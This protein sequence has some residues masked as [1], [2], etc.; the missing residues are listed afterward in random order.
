MAGS[1]HNTFLDSL[2]NI[3]ILSSAELMGVDSLYRRMPDTQ[4][5]ARELVQRGLLTGYQADQLARGNGARLLVGPY[6]LLEPIGE[7]ATGQ[8]FKARHGPMARL[9]ALKII[10]KDQV[11]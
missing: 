4:A 6:H 7:G 8:V 11:A 1:A 2:R 5:L 10:H 3:G 9:V